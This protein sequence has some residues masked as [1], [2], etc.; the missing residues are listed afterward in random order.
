MSKKGTKPEY[1]DEMRRDV[2]KA[3]KRIVSEWVGPLPTNAGDIYRRVIHSPF[4]R[5]YVSGLQCYK[6]LSRYKRGDTSVVD[7][8]PP[9]RREMYRQ[10]YE[11]CQRLQR[12]TL[13]RDESYYSICCM[14]VNHPAPRLFVGYYTVEK[15][16]IAH[17]KIVH[18]QRSNKK[19]SVA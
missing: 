19:R 2:V 12:S 6:V 16:I 9:H 4:E 11:I 8:M 13:Y 14:A 7:R 3:Y 5:Y 10:L 15:I 17:Y 1:L 18:E